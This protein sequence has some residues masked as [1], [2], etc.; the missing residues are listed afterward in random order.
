MKKWT[1][2]IAIIAV[3]TLA[4]VALLKGM[5]GAVLLSAFSIIG[6]LGGY[7]IGRKKSK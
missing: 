2:I 1:V 6:G 3:T 7:E 5:N 4:T